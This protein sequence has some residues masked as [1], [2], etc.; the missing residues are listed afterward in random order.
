M[1][2]TSSTRHRR[3]SL[4]ARQAAA[5]DLLGW[6]QDGEIRY[7]ERNQWENQQEYAFYR[8]LTGSVI[9]FWEKYRFYIEE[10]TGRP[11]KKLDREA[12]VCLL[13][14]L[15]QLDLLSGV[16]PY[17]A[18]HEA[19][20]LV[21]YLKKP[22]LKGFINGN[23][24]SF[25][26]RR[27]EL[28]EQ[29]A[30]Q[31]LAIR[32]SH[33]EWMIDRWQQ[34]YGTEAAESICWENNRTPQMH[35]VINPA[36]DPDTVIR[37]LGGSHQVADRH[38]AGLTLNDPHGLFDTRLAKSGAFL[39]QDPSSQLVGEL[40]RNLPKR[41]LLDA[42]A[43]PGGKLFHLEWQFGRQIEL[44]VAADLS[45]QRL[46]RLLA[47][48][49][50]FGSSAH[51][52]QMDASQPALSERFDLVLVDAPC[53]ATGT[54]RKHPELK[55]QRHP[56]DLAAN[57]ERQLRILEGIQSTV[58]EGGCLLY[59]TCSLEQEEN[60]EV[61]RRFMAKSQGAFHRA[62]FTPQDADPAFITAE[63]YFR[64]LPQEKA[65]G[66]FAALLKRGPI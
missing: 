52:I 48:R 11:V 33:P 56:D 35:I 23:L 47:N 17:A 41:R 14:G 16:Q 27:G 43:S 12:V 40:I 34:Q 5:L 49:N 66:L 45:A 9:R 59:I 57:Q 65:M 46:Q 7:R 60:E 36:A 64:C 3:Q 31:S 29:L 37:D 30:A 32:S 19:V 8:N 51:I 50:R 39:V 1:A 44:L 54:I 21:T 61:I 2:T 63:G 6:L 28:A 20:S 24:R 18:V 15:V 58:D 62:P 22:H 26:R 53:S 10:L 38:G 42:C 4:S 55:W 13:L 25:Q